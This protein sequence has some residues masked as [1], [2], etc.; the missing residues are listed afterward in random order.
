[1]FFLTLIGLFVPFVLFAQVMESA[2]YRIQF[3]SVNVGGGR[4]TSSSYG[5]ED[6]I[7]EVATGRSGSTNYNLQAGYQQMD[8]VS[9]SLSAADNVVMAPSLGGIS[10][11]TADGQTIATSTT[12]GQAGYELS[13]KA[14]STPAMQRNGGG[15]SIADYTPAGA[16]P[17]FTFSVAVSDAEFAFTPE[18][19]DIAQRYQDNG[20]DTCDTD[21]NDTA[22]S[23]WDAL[24]TSNVVIARRT[25]ANNP[26]GTP[27]TVKFRVGIGSSAFQLEGTYVA[28]T[29]LT[30]IAL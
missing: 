14:S 12:N 27:T 13:I 28:T 1:M 7:G 11:G 26:D 2:S 4:A 30:L 5:I 22:N 24:S 3:D 6:T 23:C 8:Q 9:L 10:G 21:S 25:S 17:D 18:G 20:A 19:E 29:T 16:V 15:A